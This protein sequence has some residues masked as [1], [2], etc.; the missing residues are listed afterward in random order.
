[1]GGLQGLPSLLFPI[2]VLC[3]IYTQNL[4]LLSYY[5]AIKTPCI[6]CST[7]IKSSSVM[8]SAA[9]NAITLLARTF[10][11][12]MSSSLATPVYRLGILLYIR[13]SLLRAGVHDIRERVAYGRTVARLVSVRRTIGEWRVGVV[14]FLPGT[15]RGVG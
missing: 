10:A 2:L 15:S 3:R 12:K 6:R 8:R 13:L 1:M 14:V 5:C 9:R 11:L 7:L 4:L